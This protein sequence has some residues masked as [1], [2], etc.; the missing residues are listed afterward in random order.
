MRF[1]RTMA[2]A[3]SLLL[4]AA[5]AALAPAPAQAQALSQSV[6]ALYPPETGEV[7]FVDLQV[8]RR[9]PHFNRLKEQVLPERFR[10]LERLSA[11]MGVDFNRNVDR[12]SYAFVSTTGDPKDADF[13]G[14]AEGAFEL[15]EAQRLAAAQKLVSS[16]K[17]PVAVYVLGRND[18]GNEFVFAFRDNATLLFG[19]RNQ[20]EGMLERAGGPD[21]VGTGGAGGRSLMDNAEMRDLINSV[22]RAAPIWMALNGEF[23]QLAVRQFLGEEASLPGVESMTERVRNATIRI[24]LGQ[25]LNS[26]MSTRCASATDA[27]WFSGLLQTALYFQRQRLNSE[28]PTLAKVIGDA[29]LE[30]TGERIS[31]A[32]SIPEDDLATLVNSNSF[33]VRF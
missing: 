6:M 29:K 27:L 24:T 15:R 1:R 10:D 19:F 23:T 11:S 3:V 32:V 2:A 5:V 18:R 17:G 8:A 22:N 13:V 4:G 31:L 9:S 26:T 14:V 21:S 16:D 30:R 33:T 25:G 7:V 12:I 20:V 28:N